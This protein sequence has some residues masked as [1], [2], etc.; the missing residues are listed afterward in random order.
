MKATPLQTFRRRLRAP[1]EAALARLAILLVPALPRRV[2]LVLARAAARLGYA[3]SPSTRRIGL[4]N[5]ALVFPDLPPARRKAIL[6]ASLRNFALSMLDLFWFA[7]HTRERMS[8]LLTVA[9]DLRAVAEAPI[10]RVGL[11][12]HL[13]NWELVGRYWGSLPGGLLSVAMPVKNTTVDALFKALRANTGQQIIPP[14]YALRHMLHHLAAKH[15]VGLLLDQCTPPWRGGIFVPFFG[16]PASISPIVGPLVRN[17]RAI[18]FF[19]YALPN[20]DGSY[21]A[22]LARAVPPEDIDAIA[23][24]LPRAEAAERVA[25]AV[26]RW[27]EEDIR[28]YP[29]AW[30]WSYKRWHH[31]PAGADPARYPSYAKP[32][33]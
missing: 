23:A 4:E 11:T 21:R 14:A 20:P 10:P 18:L 25:A 31:I 27:Y 2:L 12:A 33:T 30:L 3:L 17:T 22:I 24:G 32:A 7:R 13:G 8:R 1:F 16:L 15:T 28:Q 9:D 5:L 19:T 26:A 29:E 6:L